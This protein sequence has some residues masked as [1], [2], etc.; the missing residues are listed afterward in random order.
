MHIFIIPHSL[1]TYNSFDDIGI[2]LTMSH[3]RKSASYHEVLYDTHY[4]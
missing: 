2:Q 1:H 3:I 4:K